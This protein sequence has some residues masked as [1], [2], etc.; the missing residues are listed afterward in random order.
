MPDLP[1]SPPRSEL[2]IYQTEDGRTRIQVRLEDETVW[3]TQADMARLFQTT[4]QNITLHLKNIFQEG[5]LDEAANC[6]DFL[7]VQTEAGRQVQRSRK[8]YNLDA[9]ISVGY[10][11]KS[12]VATR[13]RQWATQRLREYIVKGFTLDDERLKQA[14]GSNYFDELL[15]R[16]RDIRAS[17]KVFWRKVLDIYATSIDYD[18]NA[19]MSRRFFQIVA[20]EQPEIHLHPALQADLG[21][22]FIQSALGPGRNRF[23][24]ETHSE[25]LLLRV[26]RRMRETS[27]DELPEGVPAITPK[28]VCVLFVQPKGT[29][30]AV[31]HLE[32]DEEGQLL[33]AWPGGF[34]EKGYRER[35]A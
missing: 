27:N 26:M 17:E 20:I 28:D 22:V 21:D 4:P 7:Q 3:L 10:R 14:G 35:F 13:F 5:E 11:I 1:A 19:E 6:K 34:F 15:A 31:R 16:I 33:D 30:S 29:S 18:P 24:I 8:F 25:H 23:L 12:H 32:L 9:I 2:L